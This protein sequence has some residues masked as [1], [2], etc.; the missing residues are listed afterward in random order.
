[1]QIWYISDGKAGHRAQALGLIAALER[2]L[3]QVQWLEL[4]AQQLSVS[5][6]LLHW[7]SAGSFGHLPELIKNTSSPDLIIGVGHQ[8]HWKVLLLKRNF[9]AAK[10]L[11]L[12][13][14]SLPLSWFD[15][16][17]IPEH[18]SPVTQPNVF[19]SRGVLNPVINEQRH[20]PGRGLILIGGP[21]KRHGW[22][23]PD[24]LFQLQ[25]IFAQYQG[26]ELIVTTSR[27]TP[28]HFLQQEFFQYLPE[29]ARL[30]PVEHTP[31]GWLFEQ[32]QLSAMVWVT[33]DS[34]SMLYEALTAGCQVQ[35]IAMPRLKRDRITYSIDQLLEQ[36]IVGRSGQ[37][38]I[39]QIVPA[40]LNE[41]DRAANWLIQQIQGE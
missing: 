7:L 13:Q 19:I 20:Q 10:T 21:S 8:T 18:D 17:I 23:D 34:I 27:R 15:Y 5:A 31:V 32:L 11:V 36:H 14:P 24:I 16:L 3:I 9:P 22:S 6:L 37:P 28:E 4:A 38:A 35:L 29:Y 30:C 12:M 40:P 26:D 25:Q 1:M 41:A 39:D 33:E 2:Q